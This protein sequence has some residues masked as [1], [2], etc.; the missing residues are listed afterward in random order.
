MPAGINKRRKQIGTRRG[1]GATQVDILRYFAFETL[2]ATL[3]E[4][5]LGAV[6]TVGF[7]IALTINF[8]MPTL[9]WYYT[10]L[11]MLGLSLLEQPAVLGPTSGAARTQPAVATRA[12]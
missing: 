8:T 3:I 2:F 6:L 10:P 7:S 4:V 11:G 5:S 12:T 1:L 9:S